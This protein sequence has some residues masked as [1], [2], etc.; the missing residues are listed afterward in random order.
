MSDGHEGVED[1][2]EVVERALSDGTRCK[3]ED[4]NKYIVEVERVIMSAPKLTCHLFFP[5]A[6]MMIGCLSLSNTWMGLK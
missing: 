5:W 1:T 6:V 4:M 3:M 2:W